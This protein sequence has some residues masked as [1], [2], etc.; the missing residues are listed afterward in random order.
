MWSRARSG[1]SLFFRTASMAPPGR[2]TFLEP[3]MAGPHKD[4]SK[5]VVY[6]IGTIVRFEWAINFDKPDLQLWQDNRPGDAQ[7]GPN[8]II[9]GTCSRLAAGVVKRQMYLRERRNLANGRQQR[10]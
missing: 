5:N 8:A 2:N 6:S 1:L 4:Y 9:E 7:G 10:R 3:W